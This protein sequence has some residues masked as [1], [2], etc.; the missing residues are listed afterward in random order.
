[1]ICDVAFNLPIRREFTYLVPQTWQESVRTGDRVVAPLSGKQA[2][3]IVVATRKGDEP[4]GLKE[5]IRPAYGYRIPADVLDL[6]RWTAEYYLASLGE[7]LFAGVGPSIS[8]AKLTYRLKRL[9]WNDKRQRSPRLTASD[10]ELLDALTAR[11][12][13]TIDTIVRQTDRN[14]RAVDSM[15]RRLIAHGLVTGEWKFATPPLPRGARIFGLR[16]LSDAIIPDDVR[17]V[18]DSLPSEGASIES[19]APSLPGGAA[20]LRDLIN[21]GA[22]DWDPFGARFRPTGS[23]PAP[24][25]GPELFDA[26]QIIVWE[27]LKELLGRDTSATA[28]LW[29]PTGSGK[30]ALYCAAIR[31]V[32]SQGRTALFLV[33]EIGLASQMIRRLEISLGERVAV[34]HSGLSLHERLWIGQLVAQGRYRLVVGARSAIF[35]PIPSLGLIVVDEEHSDSYKQSDPSPRYHARDLAVVRARLNKALCLLGSATPS[36]ESVHNAQSGKYQMLRLTRRVQGQSLPTVRV[37]DLRHRGETRHDSWISSELRD[38]IVA[39]IREGRKA[40]IF[41]NRRGHSTLVTCRL[42]GHTEVCPDCG[43]AL[44]YHASDRT[45]RCHICNRSLPARDSCAACH[46]TEFLLRG[47]GT[48]KIEEALIE[49]DPQIRL[50]RLDADIA[51]RVGAAAEVL[52]GFSGDR[53][54]TLVGTQMVTKGLDIADVGTVGVVWADQQMAY[55]DF[56]AE[57]RTF[58]LLTQVAGRAGRRAGAHAKVIVQTFHPEHELIEL[59]ASQDAESFYL[60]ELPRR[61][62]L[63]YPP[64]T[65]LI[66]LSFSSELDRA[67]ME[68]AL[69]FAAFWRKRS[70][71]QRVAAGR[72]LGPAPALIARRGNRYYV[73]ALIKTQ[74]IRK[75]TAA[76]REYLESGAPALRRRQ[77]SLTV[78]VDPVDF[79]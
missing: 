30:T 52:D 18:F 1:M 55:P 73:S 75:A 6:A 74:Q 24:E 67:P 41:L 54:N 45:C 38:R 2:T 34:W 43:L 70:E 72:L 77:V 51:A 20:A 23:N 16:R 42:C 76:V 13:V 47:V 66:S 79:S 14:R 12:A 46:G 7:S 40:L 59:A 60:R 58:Q 27:Q 37:V 49:L 26:E 64:Y 19:L 57:E 22:V 21:A 28:L 78:D 62:L 36:C 44:T 63:G 69:E 9:D 65:R 25:P 35:A 17:P 11:R 8:D 32:W 71:S 5:L 3:G 10:R 61:Q 50:A 15:L 39:T 29:G 33:P 31:H 53:Y 4:E 56:R 68:V 48:Q